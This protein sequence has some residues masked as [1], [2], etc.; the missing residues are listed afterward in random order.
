VEVF[1]EPEK[2]NEVFNNI[3]RFVMDRGLGQRLDFDHSLA[4]P[5]WV[6]Q[7]RSHVD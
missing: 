4:Y 7:L 6:Q 5:G 1:G 2:L 3:M